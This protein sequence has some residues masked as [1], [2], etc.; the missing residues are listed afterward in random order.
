MKELQSLSDLDHAFETSK[1]KTIAIF[2]HS[3][4]C[5]ISRMVLKDYKS[6]L[7]ALELENVELYYL[8][9]IA[10][11]DVSNA[12]ELRTGVIH[13]SPQL[14]KIKEGAVLH[15]ASHSSISAKDLV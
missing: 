6:E 15:H 11:R 5:G 2:K 10:Y 1:E 13:E 12:I 14:I 9:L 3:T 8:D 4:R 7:E